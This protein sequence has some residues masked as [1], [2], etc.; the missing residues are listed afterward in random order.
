MIPTVDIATNPDTV[1]LGTTSPTTSPMTSSANPPTVHPA[2]D[3]LDAAPPAA[4]FP[5]QARHVKLDSPERLP[6]VTTVAAPA[7][8]SAPAAAVP[9]VAAPAPAATPT[10]PSTS[11]G[12]SP[13]SSTTVRYV[14]AG[15]RLA[16]GWMFLWA[17]LDRAF[18]L[19]RSTPSAKSWSHGGSPTRDF[20]GSDARGP[21]SGLSH[22]M[23][24]TW[25]V[26][27]ICMTA[28]LVVGAALILGIGMRL[29]AGAGALSMV[30]AWA[31]VLPPRSGPRL[32]GH[33]ADPACPLA[34]LATRRPRT[35]AA[36]R[37]PHAPALS[38]DRDMTYACH[39]Y[40]TP[41][42]HDQT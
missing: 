32:D 40:D 34:H 21:F 4:P 22:S 14:L 23:A 35:S 39:V 26:D 9:T 24:G 18:G 2:P 10:A 41:G 1:T 29:A 16:L 33:H 8:A 31:A 42:I 19:G 20:L 28:L 37:Q 15:V 11:T 27:A 30:L 5:S 38:R 6:T 17:F 3:A 13:G 25:P 36:S 7:P 12:L